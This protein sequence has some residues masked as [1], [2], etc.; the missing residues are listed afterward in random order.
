MA[1]L[2]PTTAGAATTTDISPSPQPPAFM[3]EFAMRRNTT[4]HLLPLGT[5]PG[6]NR[7]D[8]VSTPTPS[9]STTENKEAAANNASNAITPAAALLAHNSTE[10]DPNQIPLEGLDTV[11]SSSKNKK[12]KRT[13]EDGPTARQKVL[14]SFIWLFSAFFGVATC[15]PDKIFGVEMS[16][17]ILEEQLRT[18]PPSLGTP[19]NMDLTYCAVKT[20]L[21]DLLDY[22]S[23]SATLV[24][25]LVIG[26][27]FTGLLQVCQCTVHFSYILVQ[28][29]VFP[30]PRAF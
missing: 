30:I 22:L 1:F 24:I 2:D 28:T 3:T 6:V 19:R 17:K 27:C 11:P 9:T 14:V 8:S 16:Q 13:I 29:A 23:F 4:N 26:P 20:G 5:G 15:F 10:S 25:P 18:I 12:P 7:N 21:N